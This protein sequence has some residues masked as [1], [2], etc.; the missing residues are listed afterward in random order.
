[1]KRWIWPV[2]AAAAIGLAGC[3]SSGATGTGAATTT[4]PSNAAPSGT[5]AASGTSASSGASGAS[6]PATT[7]TSGTSGT[8]GA[9]G[10]A[11]ECTTGQL[12]AGLT[13]ANGTAGSVYYQL[14]LTN[15]SGSTC[16]VEGYPGVSFVTGQTGSQVGAAAKRQPDPSAPGTP[17]IV[18][19]PGKSAASVLRIVEA[20]N[21]PQNTCAPTNVPGL[22]V[23]PPDQR[24][25]LFVPSTQQACA[26]PS[27][28][29]LTVEPLQP[30]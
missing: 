18:L 2:A 8:S 5:S 29:V 23:Y 9:A 1:M 10:T 27:V 11:A 24:V 13:G 25:S 19:A 28:S 12:A 4:T 30:S 21:F 26:G 15:N 3:G 22:R 7:G 17:R 20:G 6:D 16:F 14:V